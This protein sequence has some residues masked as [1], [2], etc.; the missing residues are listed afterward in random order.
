KERR[1]AVITGGAN[2]IGRASA[3]RIAQEGRDV[4]I[5]D[6][7]PV[8]EKVVE[9]VRALGQEALFIPTDVTDEAAVD[10]MVAQTVEKFGRLD[11]LVCSAGIL[12]KEAPLSEQSA[13]QFE[14]VMR[15]NVFGV[16]HAHR[17]AI[18]QMLKGGWG[19]CVTLTSGARH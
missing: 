15:I 18:P 12:G 19:R 6:Y 4:V 8:G 10:A 17:A 14:K 9:E 16:Y 11:I 3:L 1:V 7:D 5:A 13:E 2:G